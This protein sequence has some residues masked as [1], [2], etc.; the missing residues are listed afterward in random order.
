MVKIKK[1]LGLALFVFSINSFADGIDNDK[2]F[3]GKNIASYPDEIEAWRNYQGVWIKELSRTQ[4]PNGHFMLDRRNVNY[5]R[6]F[7]TW[8]CYY[9]I[10]N[11]SKTCINPGDSPHNVNV[12]DPPVGIH[13]ISEP[14]IIELLGVGLLIIGIKL[15][16]RYKK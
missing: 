9:S 14:E 10:V 5:W 1:Y 16:L 12:S 3:Y 4:L 11:N 15:R 7:D 8:P 2:S 6:D 13:N